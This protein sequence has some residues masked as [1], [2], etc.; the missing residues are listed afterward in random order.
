V[1][2]V[3]HCAGRR[4]F[5]VGGCIPYQSKTAVIAHSTM[6]D[7]KK[8]YSASPWKEFASPQLFHFVWSRLGCLGNQAQRSRKDSILDSNHSHSEKST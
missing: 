5:Y 7:F 1:E 3:A 4:P 6:G 8:E 2:D